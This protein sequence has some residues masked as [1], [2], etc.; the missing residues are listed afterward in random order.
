MFIAKY[1]IHQC[2][3]T[4]NTTRVRKM[5]LY[6]VYKTAILKSELYSEKSVLAGKVSFLSGER[7]F[8]QSDWEIQNKP[9]TLSNSF[10]VVMI[11][12]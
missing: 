7:D 1:T 4:A 10:K 6:Y 5:N 12:K 11:Y 9:T 8:G 3:V 2:L